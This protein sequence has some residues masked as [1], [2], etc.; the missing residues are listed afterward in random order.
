MTRPPFFVFA[1]FA[2]CLKKQSVTG[3]MV[4]PGFVRESSEKVL[5]MSGFRGTK[6][7][8]RRDHS[9]A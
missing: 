2:R 3:T 8:T 5:K 1:R 9:L 7:R 6:R 4:P